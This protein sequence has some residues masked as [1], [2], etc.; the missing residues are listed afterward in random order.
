MKPGGDNVVD[1]Y[2][3]GRIVIDGKEF[4]DDLIILPDRIKSKWWRDEGHRLQAQDLD[5]VFEARPEV[6]IVGTGFAGVMSIDEGL[7]RRLRQEGI[8][9]L[10]R[11]TTQ[12]C[13]EY[14]RLAAT[15]RV[16]AALHLTC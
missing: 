4:T 10:V 9:L 6:L 15:R 16:A 3:F 14:N 2:S 1:D 12:A 13:E 7:R 11:R 5:D 8:E